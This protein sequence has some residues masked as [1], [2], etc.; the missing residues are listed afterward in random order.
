M[1]NDFA[2]VPRKKATGNLLSL[3]AMVLLALCF[4]MVAPAPKAMAQSS[5]RYSIQEVI[6]AGHG[7]FQ[8]TSGHIA[9]AIEKVYAKRG[10]PN[11]YILGEEAS[12]AFIGGLRYGEGVLYTKECRRPQNVLAGTIDW[13]GLWRGWKPHH[14]AGL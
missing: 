8:S 4:T 3:T 2:Y 5:D 9:S 11:G 6:D 12:G 1:N 10:Q 7:F 13:L 14:D